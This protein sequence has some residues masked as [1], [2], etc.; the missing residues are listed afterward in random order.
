[1]ILGLTG[2]YCAG[3]NTVASL[4]EKRG[5]KC[6]DV[7]LLGHEALHDCKEQIVKRFGITV[8]G[9]DGEIDR[10]ALGALVFSDPAALA[11]HEAIVHPR[12]SALLD[13]RI[14]EFAAEAYQTGM[15]PLI[16]IN[17]AV[18]YKLPQLARCSAVI[19]VR[20]RM[21]ARLRRGEGRDGLYAADV[22]KRIA[23]QAPLWRLRSRYR[24]TV[25]FLDNSSD[26]AELRNRLTVCLGKLRNLSAE[27]SIFPAE[28]ADKFKR[29]P[30][31][32]AGTRT[33]NPAFMENNRMAG[34][35]RKFLWIALSLCV[36]VLILVAAGLLLFNPRG[37]TGE[38]PASAANT[39]APKA[40]DPQDFLVAPPPAPTDSTDSKGSGDVIV[41]YGNQMEP[42]STTV[43][44][45]GAL[46]SSGSSTTTIAAKLP[47]STTTSVGRSA[48]QA[49]TT[50]TSPLQLTPI[51][52]SPDSPIIAA[53]AR[54]TTTTTTVRKVVAKPKPTPKPA[55]KPAVKAVV[56]PSPKPA[57]APIASS[58]A[59]AEADIAWIQ[60]GSFQ[61]RSG[62]DTLRDNFTSAGI[63][64]V[65]MVRDIDGKSW[66]QVRV[67]PF[68]GKNQA[69]EWL[70]RVRAVSGA[71][72][73]SYVTSD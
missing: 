28:T 59:A 8:L 49:S 54:E 53:D 62:A 2:G 60:T 50:T 73:A 44:K 31:G 72:K 71:S 64:S 11:D 34:E 70:V 46:P 33:R 52:P 27:K 29:N 10:K 38:T 23:G 51:M 18:L 55:T 12:M 58:P 13:S 3:K 25:I 65:I 41:V 43:Q 36:F 42:T 61:S 56:K 39:A 30:A 19:E 37:N 47:T 20:A 1:M 32:G 57:V 15:D 35:N 16:C 6:V 26:I 40:T 63:G 67:G 69:R 66:F 21:A 4:L 7:D 5:W 24:G 22:R 17:A 14:D 9:L 68:S 48:T 45:T